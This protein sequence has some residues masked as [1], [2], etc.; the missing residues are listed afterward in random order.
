MIG[1]GAFGCTVAVK[2]MTSGMQ[3]IE[4]VFAD[5]QNKG[6]GQSGC[7]KFVRLN[8][9]ALK[10]YGCLRDRVR[11]TEET[12]VD[13][14]RSALEDTDVLFITAG[15][16]GCTGTRS[17][18]IISLFAREMGIVTVGVVTLPLDHEGKYRTIIADQGLIELRANID[19]LIVRPH[20]KLL[21]SLG[22]AVT[23]AELSDYCV[24]QIKSV[25]G[26]IVANTEVRG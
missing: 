9:S 5:S 26:G 22:D 3:E 11:E 23:A 1:V 19:S 24:A 20:D 18:P 4:Y 16:G 10:H 14:I 7:H 13:S 15:L 8:R 6:T 2:I 21:E 17:A 25:V 12:V